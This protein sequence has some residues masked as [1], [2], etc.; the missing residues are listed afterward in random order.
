MLQNCYQTFGEWWE[1]LNEYQLL[2][3]VVCMRF[4]VKLIWLQNGKNGENTLKNAAK[5]FSYE[6]SRIKKLKSTTIT[7]VKEQT[8][9]AIYRECSTIFGKT[10][11]ILLNVCTQTWARE[12]I[13][14]Y[15]VQSTL[16]R[17]L[18]S[19]KRFIMS[20]KIHAIKD[21]ICMQVYTLIQNNLLLLFGTQCAR[22]LSTI[23]IRL[24]C[25]MRQ[26]NRNRAY[27]WTFL[28][29]LFSFLSF[30]FMNSRMMCSA[31]LG[32]THYL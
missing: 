13:A 6:K 19:G 11:A 7:S 10:I 27:K 25:W 32:L 15:L 22:L 31:P 12:S 3:I 17:Q 16:Q 1:V 2:T 28:F 4:K 20:A 29:F 23:F 26:R 9:D 8:N 14:M 24:T 5:F 21:H 30:L 18:S